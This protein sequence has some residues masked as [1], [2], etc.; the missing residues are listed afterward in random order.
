[1]KPQ[2]Q[3]REVL[4]RNREI[5]GSVKDFDVWQEGMFAFR[6]DVPLNSQLG[7]LACN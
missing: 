2:W 6:E 5:D 1:M 7:I 4:V 3:G